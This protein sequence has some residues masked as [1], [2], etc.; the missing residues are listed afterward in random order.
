MLGNQ[1][2]APSDAIAAGHIISQTPAASDEV[3]KDTP[4]DIMMSTG[5]E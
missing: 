2:E 1:S 3:P 5:P 4:V